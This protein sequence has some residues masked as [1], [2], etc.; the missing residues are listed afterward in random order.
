MRVTILIPFGNFYTNTQFAL[1]LSN[2]LVY[3]T[4]NGIQIENIFATERNMI[5]WA[6][7]ALAEKALTTTSDYFLWLDDD[8]VFPANTLVRLARNRDLPIVT[9]LACE[10]RTR[11]PIVPYKKELETEEGQ[12]YMRYELPHP[13]ET[14]NS[15]VKCDGIGFGFVLMKRE[16]LEGMTPPYFR[17]IGNEGEDSYFS[18]KAEAAGFACYVDGETVIGHMGQP[19]TVYPMRVEE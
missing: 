7:Q 4:N 16:V 3:S 10:K 13:I 15:L 8:H 2:M 11:Q 5:H 9:A 14:P 17:F 12:T 18:T 6:R 1:S 19:N